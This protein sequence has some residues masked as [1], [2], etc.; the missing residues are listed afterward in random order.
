MLISFAMPVY[1]KEEYL[2]D[3]IDS[4][5]DQTYQNIELV[6]VDDATPPSHGIRE[7]V[8]YFQKHDKRVRY[9]RNKKNMG[10]ANTR[11][12]ANS[13]ARGKIICVQ[14]SDDLSYPHRAQIVYDY[15]KKNK[16]VH[17][18]YGSCEL[19]SDMGKP[20]A[21][22][23]A[24]DF[25]ISRMKRGNYINHLTVA[26]KRDIGVKYRKDCRYIDDWYF[27]LDCVKNGVKIEGVL[28]TLGIYRI[29]PDGL[30]LKDGFLPKKKVIQR[31]ALIEEFKDLE[32]DLSEKLKVGKLQQGRVKAIMK[33]I[34][35]KSVVMDLGCNGGYLLEKLKG[36]G[37]KVSGIE[38]SQYLVNICQ[39]KGLSVI[40]DDVRTAKLTQKFHRIILGDILEHYYSLTVRDI[41]KNALGALKKKGQIIITVPHKHGCYNAK[42]IPEHKRDYDVDDFKHMFPKNR[43]KVKYIKYEDYATPIWSL[44]IIN[45]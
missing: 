16:N 8:G 3:A 12:V 30:T 45:K 9:F 32:E 22:R 21:K 1:K 31:N 10:V 15:F 39:Q 41:L 14:D 24:A 6:I 37:C 44:I 36:K 5:L 2:R 20:V 11:N 13:K 27:Y 4:I 40:K 43:I 42:N 23:E 18:M 25:N 19:V 34:P 28:Q 38:T 33:E 7:I 26:Y 17:L 29:L 35:K